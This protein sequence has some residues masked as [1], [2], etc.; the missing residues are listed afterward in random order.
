MNDEYNIREKE[1]IKGRGGKMKIKVGMEDWKIFRF[2][3]T[4]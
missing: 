4:F 3:F 2:D 1:M